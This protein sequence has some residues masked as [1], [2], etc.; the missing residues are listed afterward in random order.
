MFR[1]F[2]QKKK[3]CMLLV[4]II[5]YLYNKDKKQVKLNYITAKAIF[6]PLI[7]YN[8]WTNKARMRRKKIICVYIYRFIVIFKSQRKANKKAQPRKKP[9]EQVKE[10]IATKFVCF[11]C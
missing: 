10:N 2:V 11:L 5:L 4:S 1:F 3:S 8:T 6:Y 9:S 7:I